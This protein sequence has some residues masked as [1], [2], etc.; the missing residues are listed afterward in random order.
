MVY[1][2]P[3]LDGIDIDEPL[4]QQTRVNP[5]ST[6]LEATKDI[7]QLENQLTAADAKVESYA[8]LAANKARSSKVRALSIESRILRQEVFDWE[9]FAQRVKD[10]L[11]QHLALE[12][13]IRSRLQMLEDELEIK[14][15]EMRE[16][17]WELDT[18]RARVKDAEGLLEINLNLEKRIDVLTSLLVISP[19]KL[20]LGSV[21]S[22]PCKMKDHRSTAGAFITWRLTALVEHWCGRVISGSQTC[23]LQLQYFIFFRRNEPIN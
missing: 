16:L 4:N 22:S 1:A 7:E 23:R 8:S 2:H 21:P 13:G 20:D 14:D 12:V 11:D 10:E 3:L 19:T 6:S 9:N 17:E 18:L 5:R 15:V